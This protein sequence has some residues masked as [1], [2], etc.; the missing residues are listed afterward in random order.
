MAVP[1]FSV[2]AKARRVEIRTSVNCIASYSGARAL[3]C[4]GSGTMNEENP[5]SSVIPRSCVLC[6]YLS[7]LVTT[8]LWGS[9]RVVSGRMAGEGGLGRKKPAWL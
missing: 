3:M 4:A 9:L 6:K 7:C 2:K 5:R 1:L 8:G